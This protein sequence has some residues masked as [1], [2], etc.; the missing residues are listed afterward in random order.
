MLWNRRE[1]DGRGVLPDPESIGST[2][3]T[4]ACSDTESAEVRW[5]QR[6]DQVPAYGMRW[7]REPVHALAEGTCSDLDC[8]RNAATVDSCSGFRFP[9]IFWV[10]L[11]V[12]WAYRKK[13]A[14]YTHKSGKST[15]FY[16]VYG[17]MQEN[18]YFVPLL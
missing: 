8:L 13:F 10:F 16:L 6:S 11:E 17:P 15:I 7:L 3:A 1:C 14:F 4:T 9:G 12:S 5:S 18:F 2:V